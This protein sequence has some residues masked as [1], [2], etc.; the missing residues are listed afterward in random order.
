MNVRCKEKHVSLVW[1]LD[2][3]LIEDIYLVCW[4]SV[5]TENQF[6]YV[7]NVFLS[8]MHRILDLSDK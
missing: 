2:S 1:K 6:Q 3:L 4:Q 5:K 8:C 7:V